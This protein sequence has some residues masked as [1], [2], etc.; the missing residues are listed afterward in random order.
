MKQVI[1]HTTI[2]L[3]TIVLFI[4][5]ATGDQIQ[6]LRWSDLIKEITLEDPFK[7]LEPDQLSD[8]AIIARLRQLQAKGDQPSEG[9]IKEM[10]EST[11]RLEEANIDIDGLLAK[12]TETTELRKQ[13]G[14][15]VREDL[16]GQQVRMPGYALPLEFTDAKVTQFL[17]VPWVGACIHTPPPPPNQIVFVTFDEGV[18]IKGLFS[19]FWI[20][21]EMSVQSATKNLFFVDGSADINVGYTIN[22][23]QVQPYKK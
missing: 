13:Q 6:E 8:L 16:D 10:E 14:A 1:Y 5:P 11:R 23:N 19:P 12:R 20:T 9:A 18:E 3:L 17:L 15:A 2:S 4:V 7:I 22:A 21:G